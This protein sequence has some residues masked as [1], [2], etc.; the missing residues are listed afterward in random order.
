[1]SKARLII[2]ALF[3]EGQKPSEVAQRYDVHRAWVYKLKARYEAEGEAA[4]EPRSKRPRSSPTAVD[5]AT[6]ELIIRLRKQL[7]E[8]GLDAGPDTI[9]WHLLHHHGATV[10]RATVSRQLSKAGL[11]TPE[12]NKRPRSSYIRFEAEMPNQCWQS[13]FT[14]YPLSDGTDTEILTWL[15]DCS[16]KA[17]SVT[18]HPRVTGPIVLNTFRATVDTYGPP[19]A[20]LT[21]N[22]MVFTTRLSGGKGGRNALETELRRLN[23]VQKNSRPNHPTTC[24]KVERFQCATRRTVVSP[25]LAG[26]NSKGGCWV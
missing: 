16:R 9:C 1:M 17:L 25:A 12:P 22:G 14:H 4:L 23:I 2:T 13:D 24:G 15:D 5:P 8:Q 11:I 6:L 20:T 3:V 19:A 26:N 18:A 7:S 10:S 21:D